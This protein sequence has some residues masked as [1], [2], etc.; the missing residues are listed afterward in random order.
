MSNTFPRETTTLDSVG[1]VPGLKL[2]S[3]MPRCQGCLGI[4]NAVL[5]HG[6]H[7]GPQSDRVPH[8]AKPAVSFL[9]RLFVQADAKRC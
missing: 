8:Q 5:L 6:R 2:F 3:N 9:I 7:E 1:R 4:A